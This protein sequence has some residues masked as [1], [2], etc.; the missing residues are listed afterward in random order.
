AFGASL[1]QGT[2]SLGVNVHSQT[3][4]VA[5]VV[6]RQAGVYLGL[7]LF[8]DGLLPGLAPTDFAPDCTTTQGQTSFIQRLSQV[9]PEPQTKLFDLRRGRIDWT[10][11]PR[12]FAIGGSTVDEVVRGGNATVALLEHIAEEPTSD[13]GEAFSRLDVSQLERLEMLDP[14]V[15]ICTDLL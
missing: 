4:G 12:N 8:A 13:P 1:T 14:D 6:A 7:P 9:L 11:Q 3:V 10:L 5:A 2:Q 15:A